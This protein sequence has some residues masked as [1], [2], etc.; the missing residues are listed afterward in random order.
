M[1]AAL[2]SAAI[3][4]G[5]G[6]VQAIG[7]AKQKNDAKNAINNYERVDISADAN[8]YRDI[9]ISTVGSDLATEENQIMSA[10]ALSALQ[11]G[12]IRGILGGLPQ[13]V[14]ANNSANRN[15]AVDLD[16]QEQARQ[17]LIARGEERLLG[18]RENRDIQNLNNLSSQYNA[19]NQDMWSG[20]S[21]IGSGLTSALGNF[22]GFTPQVSSPNALNPTGTTPLS[23]GAKISTSMPNKLF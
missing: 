20:I 11:G 13:L 17:L 21:G 7:G 23:G 1:C 22:G 15:I 4:T 16:K 8:P 5:L 6:I 12:G 2:T 10:S 14:A 3:G 9:Q 19:G 18:M